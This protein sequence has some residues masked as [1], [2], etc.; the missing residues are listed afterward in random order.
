[1]PSP[2]S[3]IDPSVGSSNP[4]ISLVPV[5]FPQPDGPS[6]VKNSFSRMSS[7]TLSSAVIV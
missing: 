5:V 4:A 1:M 7:S 3:E 6:S 2:C